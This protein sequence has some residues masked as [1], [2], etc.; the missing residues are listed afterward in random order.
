MKKVIDNVFGT[1]TALALLD[2]VIV[3]TTMMQIGAGEAVNHI[4]FWDVQ[5]KFFA[6]ILGA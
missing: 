4:A 3:F 1:I 5:I 6:H 2:L